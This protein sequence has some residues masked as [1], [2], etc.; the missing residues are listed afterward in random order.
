M[1]LKNKYEPIGPMDDDLFELPLDEIRE[2]GIPQMPH[3]L[4]GALEA[5]VRD[6][7]FLQPVFT[8]D[9]ID[10]TNIINLK[11]KYGLTKLDLLHLNLKQ[12]ILVNI[13]LSKIKRQVQMNFLWVPLF[14]YILKIYIKNK[15]IK[16]IEE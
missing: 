8:K 4:R 13:Y 12:H 6:N 5:L 10:T 11:L 7:E 14:F 3:T 16:N 9:M 15:K 1:E 2:R